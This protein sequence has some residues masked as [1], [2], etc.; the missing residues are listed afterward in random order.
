GFMNWSDTA[1]RAYLEELI[2][3]DGCFTGGRFKWFRSH[4]IYVDKQKEKY[5]FESEIGLPEVELVKDRGTKQ[6]GLVPKSYLS[7]KS[8]KNLQDDNDSAISEAVGNLV[9]VVN[10][11]TN[12]L[13]NDERKLAEDLGFKICLYPRGVSYYPRTGRVSVSWVA[14]TESLDDTIRWAMECPPNDVRKKQT[15]ESWLR[16]T[17]ENWINKRPLRNW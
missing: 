3:E 10:E 4:A 16:K 2:P 13:I 11:S 12:K 6:R 17:A 1:K 14:V 8:L 5:E 15:V 7:T 9:K